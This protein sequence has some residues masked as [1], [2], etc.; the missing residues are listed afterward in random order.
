MSSW[1]LVGFVMAKPQWELPEG[2][3]FIEVIKY[4][5]RLLGKILIQYD[6]CLHEKGKFEHSHV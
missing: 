3:I 2:K 4:K 5:I 6:W 1:I